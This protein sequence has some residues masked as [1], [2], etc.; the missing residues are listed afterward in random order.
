MVVLY[1]GHQPNE[2]VMLTRSCRRVSLQFAEHAYLVFMQGC[3]IGQSLMHPAL[4]IHP[5]PG[6]L[7]KYKT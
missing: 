1:S 6:R 7:G 5:G 2:T 3:K 4:R